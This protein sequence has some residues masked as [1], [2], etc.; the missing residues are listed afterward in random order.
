VASLAAP[1]HLVQGAG[2]FT[3]DPGSARDVV[4]SFSPTGNGYQQANLDLGSAF[5][6]AVPLD[7]TGVDPSVPQDVIGIWFDQA[8]A[9]NEYLC[10]STGYAEQVVAY[11]LLLNPSAPAGIGG[12][13]VCVVASNPTDLQ[14]AEWTLEG[15]PVNSLVPP[16]FHATLSGSGLPAVPVVQLARFTFWH[17]TTE[18][19]TLLYLTPTQE[20]YADV[21]YYI[22]AANHTR[23]IPLTVASGSPDQPVAF[24]NSG[25]P[26]GVLA[27][28]PSAAR[29]AGGV[30]LSWHDSQTEA[31]AVDVYRRIGADSP[32]RLTPLPLPLLDGR[33]DYLDAGAGVPLGAQ[34]RYSL[35]LRRGGEEIDRTPE[36]AITFTAIVPATTALHP[37]RPNPFNPET[38]V[39]FDLARTG[40]ARV[41]V[42]DC[43][44][45]RIR[46]LTD[47]SLAAGA[48]SRSWDGRDDTGRPVPSGVYY[49]RLSTGGTTNMQKLMLL[50]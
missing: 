33:L 7:G 17:P 30:M 46:T 44:G 23:H 22:D 25:S 43:T 41:E 49:C 10:T 8:A 26:V 39:S 5:C 21:P 47:G 6:S 27:T 29:T 38:T 45:R 20:S 35:G 24:V 19:S 34:L 9:S 28:A 15:Q 31:D 50:R 37:A 32:L 42:F 12:W 40:H 1:F 11:L 13:D 4:V 3:L 16:C 36:A 18:P 14:Q 48:Y 2:A